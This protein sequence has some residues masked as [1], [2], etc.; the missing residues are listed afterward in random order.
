MISAAEA[1]WMKDLR[2]CPGALTISFPNGPIAEITSPGDLIK[3]SQIAQSPCDYLDTVYGGDHP[4]APLVSMQLTVLTGLADKSHPPFE[5]AFSVALYDWIRRG[6]P[7]VN[8]KSVVE[9]FQTPFSNATSG[10]INEYQVT[11]NGT[12]AYNAVPSPAVTLP[13]SQNQF[14]TYSGLAYYSPS[15]G[16]RYD[17][18]LTNYVFQPGRT[19]GGEHAGE[20]LDGTPVAGPANAPSFIPDSNFLIGPGGGTVR[21]TYQSTGCAVDVSFKLF[22]PPVIPPGSP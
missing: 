13:V 10:V 14:Q 1:A 16:N 8:V 6:G 19:N 12:I 11:Q 15:T 4:S 21:P 7:S 20:P 5:D 17:L 9:M 18:Y 22:V 3:N 2:P